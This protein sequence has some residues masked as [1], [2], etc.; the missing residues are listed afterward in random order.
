[1]AYSIQLCDATSRLLQYG[2]LLAS[3]ETTGP[4]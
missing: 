1:M 4:I 3:E 2:L